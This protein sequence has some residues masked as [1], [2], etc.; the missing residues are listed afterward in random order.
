M[1]RQMNRM[2]KEMMKDFKEI[3][4]D[5][6]KQEEKQIDNKKPS[7]YSQN[8]QIE[9][10]QYNID[11]TNVKLRNVKYSK[12]KDDVQMGHEVKQIFCDPPVSL[13]KVKTLRD[14]LTDEHK[15]VLDQF[16]KDAD[17]FE[18]TEKPKKIERIEKIVS[19]DPETGKNDNTLKIWFENE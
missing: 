7:F 3:E 8:R 4:G 2:H 14:K 19:A 16:L 11:G 5:K 9:T 15:E 13:D 18:K 17:K 12:N 10:R 6:S 1:E